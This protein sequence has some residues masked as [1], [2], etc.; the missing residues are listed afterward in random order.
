MDLSLVS[1]DPLQM[2]VS[3]DPADSC[4]NGH[5]PGN[6]VVPGS[7]VTG[8]CLQAISSF[9]GH[10]GPL[11][12]RRFSFSRFAS[13]GEYALGIEDEGGTYLCTLSREDTIFAQGRITA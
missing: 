10:K 6:P 8:L 3:F 5:F 13:P 2:S 9:L 12:I 7:L 11:H 1:R 4:F